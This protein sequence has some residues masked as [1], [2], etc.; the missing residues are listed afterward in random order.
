MHTPPEK[1]KPSIGAVIE[2]LERMHEIARGDFK[3]VVYQK[4]HVGHLHEA[5][6]KHAIE[7]LRWLKANE[8]I[9]KQRMAQ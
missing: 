6:M 3:L 9:I 2:E 5:R 7:L 1:K 8:R 4:M